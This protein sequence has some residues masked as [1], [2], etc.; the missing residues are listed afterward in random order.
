MTANSVA[1]SRPLKLASSSRLRRLAAS[2]ISASLRSSTCSARMCGSADFCVS[3]TYCRSAPA[4]RMASGRSSAPKPFRSS[5]PSWSVSRREA[6][7]SSKCH[8]GRIRSAVPDRV[9][10]STP[11][12][13]ASSSSAGFSR[14]S[15]AASPWRPSPCSTVKRPAARSSHASPKRSPSRAR[16]PT[17]VSRRSSRR[18]VSV[19]VPGV[20]MRTT[21]RSRGPFE[22]DG[23]PSCSQIATLSP[24]RTSLAR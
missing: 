17:R 8:G 14:S 12:P 20:T 23:S 2:S 13:S 22:L 19:T 3:R 4:A 1:S 15:S 18:A 9:A 10:G 11:A 21:C 5:V 16:A 6:L 24:L 7:A